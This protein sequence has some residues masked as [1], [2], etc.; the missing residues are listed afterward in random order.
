MKTLYGILLSIASVQGF[1]MGA[2]LLLYKK[3][4]LHSNTIL[5]LLLLLLAYV[6]LTESLRV[7]NGININTISYYFFL[8]LGWLIG[9]LIYLYIK[10]LYRPDFRLSFKDWPLFFPVI[11]EACFSAFIKTQNLYWDGTR[12]SLSTI[13]YHGY[14]LWMHTPLDLVITAILVIWGIIQGKKII[15]NNSPQWKEVKTD[16]RLETIL[17]IYKLFAGAIIVITILDFLF[18]NFAF[19]P[20]YVYPVYIMLGVLTYWLA[21][22]GLLSKDEVL[23]KRKV[24][25]DEQLMSIMGTL[26]HLMTSEQ[27]YLNPELNLNLLSSKSDIKS[28]LI[29]KALNELNDKSFSQYINDYR[30]KHFIHRVNDPNYSNHTI[31]A[32]ALDCGFNS[33]A[34]ANRII[35]KITGKSPSQLRNQ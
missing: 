20:I 10:S 26:D 13:G 12:E 2:Y 34:S 30:V 32:I 9:P 24:E 15:H 21:F 28:Y 35:K 6:L 7:F 19:N 22:H 11:I 4:R 8:E 14:R 25:A 29:S 23:V 33:K 17:S 5:A 16:N 3:K 27:L 1:T 31:L 18:F